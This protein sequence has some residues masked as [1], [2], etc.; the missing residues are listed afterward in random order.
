MHRPQAVLLLLLLVP[1]VAVMLN[2]AVAAA[3]PSAA[4]CPTVDYDA[5]VV[6]AGGSG[7]Y[8]AWRLQQAKNL[9]VLVLEKKDEVGGNCDTLYF[10]TPINGVN[11]TIPIETGVIVYVN[12]SLVTETLRLLNVPASPLG[13]H[14]WWHHCCTVM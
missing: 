2:P 4:G 7:M 9:R 13:E 3:Q 14:C 10:K 6:G 12:T 8:A 11:L 5:C 1:A